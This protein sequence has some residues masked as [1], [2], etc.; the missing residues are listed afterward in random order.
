MSDPEK[1]VTYQ[2]RLP[3]SLRDAFVK[4]AKDSDNDGAKLIRE[5][6]RK[7]VRTHSQGDLLK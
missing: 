4:A 1:T 5:F 6:M 2:I 3:E 7:Y